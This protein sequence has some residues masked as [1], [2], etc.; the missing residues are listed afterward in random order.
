VR[1]DVVPD[2]GSAEWRRLREEAL[3]K[4]SWVMRPN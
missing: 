1:L 4:P 3:K 2:D